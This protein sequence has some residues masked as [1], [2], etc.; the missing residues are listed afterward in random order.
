MTS[1]A[2][3]VL[4]EWLA[5]YPGRGGADL[6]DLVERLDLALRR[7]ARAWKAVARRYR[8]AA[9]DL[10]AT[11]HLYRETLLGREP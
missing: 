10:K 8:D 6:D 4:D 3:L 11:V 9:H 1:R 7:P 5:L 2:R